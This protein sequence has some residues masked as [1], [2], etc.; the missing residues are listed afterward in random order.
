[1]LTDEIIKSN[2]T[3]AGLTDEQVS[4]IATLSRNDEN[5]VIGQ[6]IGEIYRQMDGAISEATGI[7]RNGDE[8]TY[9]YLGR[10]LKEVSERH[11]SSGERI[12]AL[13]AEK[14]RLEA[15]LSG[16]GSEES[17]RRIKELKA[18]LNAS[19]KQYADLQGKYSEAEKQFNDRISDFR[20]SAELERAVSG[21][22][23]KSGLSQGLREMAVSNVISDIK[24]SYAPSVNE[25][26]KVIFHDAD[27]APMNNPANLL[28]PLTAADILQDA[29]RKLDL[30]EVR[31]KSKGAGSSPGVQRTP[32]AY[33]TQSEAM[34]GIRQELTSQGLTR[35]SEEYQQE[36]NRIWKENEIGK[37]PVQ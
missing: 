36:M 15:A 3:L 17:E 1:M 37:L 12:Q 27:G 16:G 8:K 19:K 31:S 25:N 26:G 34:A 23:L 14:A 5:T 10:A 24:K 21:I 18:E 11:K 28:E 29:F 20:I 22:N 9:L 30:L 7:A 4:A 2:E 6:R 33:R 35:G 32:T 13:E